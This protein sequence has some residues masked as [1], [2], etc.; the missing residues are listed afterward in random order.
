MKKRIEYRVKKQ[1]N[2]WALRKA[3][4]V[5]GTYKLRRTAISAGRWLLGLDLSRKRNARLTVRDSRNRIVIRMPDQS[6]VGKAK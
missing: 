2:H 4:V 3:G 6:R 1:A 5:L